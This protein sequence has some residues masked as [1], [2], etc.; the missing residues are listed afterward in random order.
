MSK[1]EKIG[2]IVG[3]CADARD[4]D[5]NGIWHSPYG[6][7]NLLGKKMPVSKK[8]RRGKEEEE[9]IMIAQANNYFHYCA[10]CNKD[11][12]DDAIILVM[13]TARLV[14]AHCCNVMLWSSETD[15]VA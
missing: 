5:K 15:V 14:P 7:M 8:V 6:K 2:S 9:V 4:I 11:F 10:N 1:E 13:E 3:L 12:D